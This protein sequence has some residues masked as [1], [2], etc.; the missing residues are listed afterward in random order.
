MYSYLVQ[1][2]NSGLHHG[3]T[4]SRDEAVSVLKICK[5]TKTFLS[6]IT[7]S[8]IPFFHLLP[9]FINF[10]WPYQKRNVTILFPAYSV[11]GKCSH[12]SQQANTL[13]SDFAACFFTDDY[14]GG[15]PADF[16]KVE[17]DF[18]GEVRV[19]RNEFGRRACCI[20]QPTLK[21]QVVY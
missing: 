9:I 10:H 3:H 14:N 16:L 18:C 21:V 6:C 20:I 8:T 1:L 19:S 5:R 7:H 15:C 4:C 13:D 17:G 2:K 12:L 11:E